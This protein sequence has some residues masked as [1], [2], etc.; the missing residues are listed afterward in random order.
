MV[1]ISLKLRNFMSYGEDVPPLDFTAFDLAC[2]SGQNG[3]GKSALLDAITWSLWGE[4]RKARGRTSPDEDLIRIGARDMEVEFEFEVGGNRYRVIRRYSRRHHRR[5]SLE[6][7]VYSPNDNRWETLTGKT[8]HETQEKINSILRMDYE[9]FIASSFILQGRADEFTRRP[10]GERKEIL[11]SIL[12]LDHYDQLSDLA[13]EHQKKCADEEQIRMKELEGIDR[14]LEELPTLKRMAEKLGKALEEVNEEL[15]RVKSELNSKKDRLATLEERK[16][17]LEDLKEQARGIANSLNEAIRQYKTWRKQYEDLLSLLSRE[18]EIVSNYLR[19]QDALRMNN[20]LTEKLNK[21]ME[22]KER[23]QKVEQIIEKT[24]SELE[25]ELAASRER[26]KEL[27]REENEAMQWIN[28]RAEI[29]R[30]YEELQAL[31][32]KD[33]HMEEVR[34][35]DSQLRGV[36]MEIE[37]KID[38]ERQ[39][40]EMQLNSVRERYKE[41]ELVAGRRSEYEDEIAR[42]NKQ[43]SQLQEDERQ[44]SALRSRIADCE[45]RLGELSVRRTQLENEL[46][47]TRAKLNLLVESTEPRCPVCNSPL[48][49]ARK[50]MLK[51]EFESSLGS[52]QRELEVT[53]GEIEE[54]KGQRSELQSR[55]EELEERLKDMSALQEQLARARA[56]L[57]EANRAA[58]ELENL[59]REIG[60][61][62]RRLKDGD[63]AAELRDQLGA[64]EDELRR[65]GYDEIAHLQVKNAIK[66][67]SVYEV[68][69]EHLKQAEEKL[70]EVRDRLREVEGRISGLEMKLSSGDFA[71]DERKQLEELRRQ[72]K[73]LG[74]DKSEHDRVRKLQKD[75]EGY[76]GLYQRLMQAKDEK[77]KLESQLEGL[78][79]SI[80]NER[81]RYE[82]LRAQIERLGKEVEEIPQVRR[83]VEVLERNL[84]EIE[85]KRSKLE[86]ERGEIEGRISRCNELRQRRGEIEQDLE[87]IRHERDIYGLLAQIFGKDGIQAVII[88][89]AIDELEE[90][91]NN[92]LKELTHGKASVAFELQR[93]TK[94]GAVRE[95]LDIKVSD[96]LGTRPYELF[97]GG[98]SFRIDFAIRVALAK[99]L[100]KRAGTKVRFLVIDEGFGSQDSDGLK[101]LV[102]AIYG[103]RGDFDKILVVTHLEHLKDSFPVRIEVTKDP[104]IGSRFEIIHA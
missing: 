11:A 3:H 41:R 78:R 54:V 80:K 81:K 89:N 56:S 67:K 29:E 32:Q 45:R 94:G 48:D 49:E 87:R 95:T 88:G 40:L 79:Q 46:K 9:T 96:E 104:H 16:R 15:Q 100:A 55:C 76:V 6:L 12:G 64:I 77:P 43:I 44:L 74:Y 42:I 71:H 2:L 66:E 85:E 7:Q 86:R 5:T 34:K 53:V 60:E 36:A 99:L 20:E 97:S 103:I 59:A 33:E 72:I 21:L 91:A 18:S 13:R 65:L 4:A 90:E 93:E 92:L 73:E 23:A 19:Y 39:K 70:R 22:V 51:A 58:E 47:E 35:K 37:V 63:F 52:I 25:K 82:D 75:L 8:Q 27:L 98:E 61:L 17:R 83:S 57:E 10:P 28:R 31:R 84:A 26:R 38:S 50:G 24:K 14:E 69:M 68:Q 101:Q 30:G 62:E 102:E 1:P